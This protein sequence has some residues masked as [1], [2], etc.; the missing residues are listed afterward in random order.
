MKTQYSILIATD[1][2][3][4]SS[5]VNGLIERGWQVQGGVAIAQVRDEEGKEESTQWAQAMVLAGTE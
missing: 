4:L 1:P 5:Q 2:S 3:S